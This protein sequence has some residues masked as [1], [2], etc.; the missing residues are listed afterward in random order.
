MIK[1]TPR[2]PT[3]KFTSIYGRMLHAVN[4]LMNDLNKKSIVVE[5]KE[6]PRSLDDV[7]SELVTAGA[8]TIHGNTATTKSIL[9]SWKIFWDEIPMFES[10]NFPKNSSESI[11]QLQ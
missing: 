6:T 9:R 3:S 11:N 7:C 5:W 4:D 10:Q 1:S 2:N 8:L